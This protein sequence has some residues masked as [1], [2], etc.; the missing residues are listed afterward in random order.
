M[1]YFNDRASTGACQPLFHTPVDFFSRSPLALSPVTE[2]LT[3]FLES[4][5]S[6]DIVATCLIQ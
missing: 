2:S 3:T 5:Y 6:F 1:R 4:C